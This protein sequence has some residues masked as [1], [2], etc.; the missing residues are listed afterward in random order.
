MVFDPAGHLRFLTGA[1]PNMHGKISPALR[2]LLDETGIKN[3]D[4]ANPTQAWTTPE[5]LDAIGSGL[6]RKIPAQGGAGT[7]R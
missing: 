5:A 4:H 7:D 3:L 1:L 6:G 2:R